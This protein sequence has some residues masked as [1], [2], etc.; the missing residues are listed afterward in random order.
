MLSANRRGVM[1]QSESSPGEV[2]ATL[3]GNSVCLPPERRTFNAIRSHLESLALQQQRLLCWLSV[4]GEAIGLG[5]PGLR[6]TTFSRV[7]GETMGLS[8]VPLHLIQAALHQTETLRARVQSAVELVLINPPQPAREIWWTI[9]TTLKEPLLTLSLLPETICG[10]DNGR[11]PL[12]QLRK[13]QLQQLGWVIRDVD[14]AAR[15]DETSALSDALEKRVGR[16][17]DQLQQ[18]L[19]LWEEAA[20]S[21]PGP[22]V[23]H[24]S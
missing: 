19:E 16:W 15:G 3:D 7:D 6:L 9:A 18:S 22:T 13:W 11:A 4:D 24:E 21:A 10:P 14:E 17:L 2:A 23:C 12:L 1:A 8:D 20:L 5:H